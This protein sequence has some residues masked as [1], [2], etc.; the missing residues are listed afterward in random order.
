MNYIKYCFLFLILLTAVSSANAD[1]S[2]MDKVFAYEC[3]Q[4]EEKTPHLKCHYD[5]R[6]AHFIWQ[7]NPADIDKEEMK[8]AEYLMMKQVVNLYERKVPR[9]Y[10]RVKGI[11]KY[12]SCELFA[13]KEYAAPFCEFREEH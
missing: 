2:A 12:K 10:E 5:G 4:I 9:Y 1:W 7:Q 3:A 8:Y 13:S 11:N 6:R